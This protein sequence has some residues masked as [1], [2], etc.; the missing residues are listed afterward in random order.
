MQKL[1]IRSFSTLKDLEIGT[2]FPTYKPGFLK[3]ES[4]EGTLRDSIRESRIM[5][6]SATAS[7]RMNHFG[8]MVMQVNVAKTNLRKAEKY[9]SALEYSYGPM[10]ELLGKLRKDIRIY[11]RFIH[12]LN[13]HP[14]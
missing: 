2:D 5:L 9:Y 14:K 1:S 11:E 10:E 12:G 7:F 8:T 3:K 13:L 6:N 4:P